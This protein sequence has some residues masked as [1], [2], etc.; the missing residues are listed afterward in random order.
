[1][2]LLFR[3]N[4]NADDIIGTCYLDMSEISTQ[5]DKGMLQILNLK[6]G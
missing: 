5:G 4:L 3:D 1:M 2:N 6:S